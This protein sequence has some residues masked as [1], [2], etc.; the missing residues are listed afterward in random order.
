[1]AT[2]Q[3]TG[4]LLAGARGRGQQT[5]A[6]RRGA[7][8]RG[9]KD[10]G[11]KEGRGGKGAGRRR[12]G[13]PQPGHVETWV[14]EGSERRGDRGLRRESSRAQQ[15]PQ[16]LCPWDVIDAF[17]LGLPLELIDYH[18]NYVLPSM[19]YVVCNPLQV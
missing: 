16:K 14:S 4:V 10:R 17:E 1:M 7:G 5:N 11:G 12:V 6:R 9:T 18:K 8:G 13:S 2:G 3:L 15:E 19:Q